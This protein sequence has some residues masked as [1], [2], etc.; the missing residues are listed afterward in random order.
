MVEESELLSRELLSLPLA[1][2]EAGGERVARTLTE[3]P[4]A[5]H[6]WT[7]HSALFRNAEY[8]LREVASSVSL[9]D[10]G[11]ITGA[12]GLALPDGPVLTGLSR[13]DPLFR[14]GFDDHKVASIRIDQLNRRADLRWRRAEAHPIWLGQ[15]VTE[16]QR[17]IRSG[18]VSR[19][20]LEYLEVL[21]DRHEHQ[22]VL[23]QIGDVEL[24][25][26]GDFTALNLDDT[27]YILK[28]QGVEEILKTFYVNRA[29][30]HAAA[31]LIF[32]GIFSF[33]VLDSRT[34]M[35][36]SFKSQFADSHLMGDV[37]V[38]LDYFRAN[39][40]LVFDPS[41]WQRAKN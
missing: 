13:Q 2:V 14:R 21:R 30:S 11:R 7:L 29:G 33:E 26:I 4:E 27:L 9:A 25:G 40:P 24:E 19:Q 3:L 5:P 20:Q 36:E 8:L 18:S 35:Y 39:P 38:L 22:S 12:V 1:V 34:P 28:S 32:L 15:T 23:F 31:L 10:L 41:H 6:F 37:F 16:R 17:L